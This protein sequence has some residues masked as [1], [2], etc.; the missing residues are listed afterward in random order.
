[1]KMLGW[2]DGLIANLIDHV[3]YILFILCIFSYL[4]P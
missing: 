2:G 3:H 4:D 1:M